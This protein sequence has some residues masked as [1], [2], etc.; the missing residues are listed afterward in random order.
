MGTKVGTAVDV[1][2]F[3]RKGS[4]EKGESIRNNR[5]NLQVEGEVRVIES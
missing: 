5:G 4:W 1:P 2:S 3:P